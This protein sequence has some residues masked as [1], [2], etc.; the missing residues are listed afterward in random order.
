[1][2]TSI[3]SLIISLLIMIASITIKVNIV[4]A[5]PGCYHCGGS[6]GCESSAINQNGWTGC[7]M[8]DENTCVVYGGYWDC[9][10]IPQRI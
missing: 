4:A 5:S 2:K 8:Y 9:A 1:M 3:L 7:W 10:N 6:S